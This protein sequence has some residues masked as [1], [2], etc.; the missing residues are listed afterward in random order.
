MNHKYETHDTNY[1]A[2]DVWARACA[3][4]DGG[5]SICTVCHGLEGSLTTDCPEAGITENQR[6]EIYGGC[7]DYRNGAWVQKVS[8]MCP[9]KDIES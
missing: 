5:L 1:H 4:C 2:N 7:L 3:I 8:P 6:S 9:V